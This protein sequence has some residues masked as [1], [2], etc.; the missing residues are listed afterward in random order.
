MHAHL[1]QSDDMRE[2]FK[3]EA[4]IAADIECEYIVDVSDAGVDDATGM[5]FMVMELLRGEELGERLKRVGRLPPAEA[6]TYLHQT[7]VALDQTHAAGIVH[8]DLKPANLFLTQLADGSPRLKVL[9]FGVAKAIAGGGGTTGSMEIL[10]TPIYMAPE[11]FYTGTTLTAA[12]D[13]Y[14]FGLMAYTLLVGEPYWN[15]DLKNAGG[16]IPFVTV[17]VNGP[18]ESAVQR[19]AAR[20]VILPPAF[21]AWFARVT[22]AN[23][24]ARF[25]RATEAAQALGEALGIAVG[26]GRQAEASN[27][28]M[29]PGGSTPVPGVTPAGGAAVGAGHGSSPN[30]LGPATSTVP[31]LSFSPGKPSR[32]PRVIGAVLGLVVVGGAG[33]WLALR[34]GGGSLPDSQVTA[35]LAASAT[36]AAHPASSPGPEASKVVPG[37][38]TDATAASAPQGSV[39]VTPAP[40]VTPPPP[41]SSTSASASPQP[42][43]PPSATVKAKPKPA[44]A[45]TAPAAPAKSQDPFGRL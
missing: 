1:F 9:D 12:A 27:P 37:A 35:D 41:E 25:H 14:A 29:M 28:M 22:A 34:P 5:P 23:P 33:I 7:A 2:R 31:A 38:S 32:S 36:A 4:R 17:A 10:G 42:R 44:P 45:G 13:I 19:A 20:G 18:Q 3:R 15:Q 11:Q 21:D 43:T 39:T 24:A 6:L 8:R 16:L 26:A 30:L 40:P